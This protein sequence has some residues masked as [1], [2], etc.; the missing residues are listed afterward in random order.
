MAHG[1]G[2]TR[3]H[4]NQAYA[5]P[6]A[7][8]G[9]AV[10]AFDYRGWGD[11]DSKLAIAGA[12]PTPDANGEVT[13]RAHALREVVDP[14]DQVQDFEHAIDYLL[15]EPGVDPERIGIWGTSYSGGHVVYIAA[16]DPRVKCV[17]SQAGYQDSRE[18]ILRRYADKGGAAFSQLR[19]TQKA[20]GEI[21]PQPPDEDRVPSLGGTPDVSKFA[22]YR[23]IAFA[24]RIRVPLMIIDMDQ[25]ELFD[26][27]KHGR[28]VY[29]IARQNAPV[30]YRV[31]PGRHYDVYGSQHDQA[32]AFALFWFKKHLLGNP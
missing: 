24:G 2:G 3:G 31:L 1:W 21:G 30:D 6:F 7:E 11:S 9:F 10:L 28:A 29:E 5:R 19:A 26:R 23:P 17:V 15:G 18:G 12:Q 32:L 16:H 14:F 8:A 13:V 4:L 27:L 20:R 25:E 22:D